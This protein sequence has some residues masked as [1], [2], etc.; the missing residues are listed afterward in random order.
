MGLNSPG[1]SADDAADMVG[2]S[3]RRRARRAAAAAA[4]LALALAAAATGAGAETAAAA[5]HRRDP[6]PGFRAPLG[7]DA[8]LPPG[9]AKKQVAGRGAREAAEPAAPSLAE[10][11][12]L[13]RAAEPVRALAERLR[14][15]ETRRGALFLLFALA[16]GV[17][18][19]PLLVLVGIPLLRGRGDLSVHLAYPDELEGTFRVR[20]SR[21]MP[22]A[23]RPARGGETAADLG[24]DRAATRTDH[25]M[26]SR[27][28]RFQRLRAG[29]W[30]VR[31]E[32]VLQDPESDEILESRFAEERVRVR[33]GKTARVA[34]ELRPEHCPV[35][36]KVLWDK[37]PVREARVALR[38][39][40]YSVR[41]AK[42]GGVRLR[43]PRGSH[44]LVVGSGDRLAE[45]A[46]DVTS[47][48]TTWLIVDL[49]GSD[50]LVF[51]GCPAAV[52]PYLQGDFAG[53]ARALDRAGQAKVAHALL[54]R[55]DQ[56]QGRTAA[57]AEH[58]EAAD[59][60]T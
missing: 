49:G 17:V 55:L 50:E 6:P 11:P 51:K 31:V 27:E 24:L 58:F 1:S 3:R 33:R 46:I 37:R 16:A 35:D 45:R 32:G 38:G 40:P 13:R 54:A 26:V 23:R 59:R 22:R 52:E 28:T 15:P 7:P 12:E 20:V 30:W 18:G 21:R 19:G 48:R 60:L 14:A 10:R 9:Q 56:E 42:G 57:A 34:F 39:L 4:A 2:F 5:P 41:F 29:S 25:P 44:S 43:L 47:W 53:A 36:V 8:A